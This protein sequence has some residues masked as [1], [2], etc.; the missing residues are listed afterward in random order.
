ML[1]NEIFP[2]IA[3]P[4]ATETRFASAIPTLKNLFGNSFPNPAVFNES[5]VSAPNTTT[6]GFSLP[7][8]INVFPYSV[9]ISVIC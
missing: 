5:V 1:A 2:E 9:L 3:R 7:I 4:A 6:F 8:S